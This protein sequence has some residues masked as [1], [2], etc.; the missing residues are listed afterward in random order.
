MIRFVIERFIAGVLTLFCIATLS[1]FIV[2]FA[3]GNPFSTEGKVTEETIEN[4]KEHYDLDKP[5]M[6]QYIST[7][8]GYVQGDFGPTYYRRNYT[9]SELVGPALR[10]S[11]ILGGLSFILALLLGVPLGVLA[12]KFK[13]QLPDHLAMSVSIAGICIPNFL[14]GPLLIMIFGFWQGWFPVAGWPGDAIGQIFQSIGSGSLPPVSALAKLKMLVLPVI[15][16]SMMH[17]AYIARL[18]RTGMLEV[19]EEDYIRTARAKGVAEKWVVTKHALKNG[20]SPVISYLGPMTAA[21]VTGSVVVEQIFAIPGL[22]RYF[23]QSA[24][25]RDHPLLMGSILVFST[26]IIV[27]N[28][29]VDVTYSLIDPRVEAQ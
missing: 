22:G 24:L 29:L 11:A 19:L 5:L 15:T 9:V 2:R 3:P 13:N 14:L 1:F 6:E 12:A 8:G 25:S 18:T 17:V 7:M 27:F 10:K 20:I 26:L 16:L 28:F 21:I 4:L 23:V